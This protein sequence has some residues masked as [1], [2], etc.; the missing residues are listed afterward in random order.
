MPT[1]K[2]ISYGNVT[3]VVSS[4]NS[5]QRPSLSA[6]ANNTDVLCP[7]RQ[8]SN[9]HLPRFHGNEPRVGLQKDAAV[10]KMLVLERQS[11]E[12]QWKH[13]HTHTHAVHTHVCV[14]VWDMWKL[15]DCPCVHVDISAAATAVLFHLYAPCMCLHVYIL[16]SSACMWRAQPC[17]CVMYPVQSH[18]HIDPG[19]IKITKL[20]LP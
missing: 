19:Q 4:T 2:L 13:T 9:V 20:D 6:H 3:I 10:I 7:R 5:R 18:A 12:H 14:C 15:I 17:I 16:A 11:L 8:F 1:N